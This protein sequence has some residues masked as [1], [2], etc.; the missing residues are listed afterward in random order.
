MKKKLFMLFLFIFL[1]F[2]IISKALVTNSFYKNINIYFFQDDNCKECKYAKEWLEEEI[3]N[4]NNIKIEY[5][6]ID[7]D[8]KLNTKV[9]N[10]L[11]IKKNKT[12]L[13]IIGSNYFIGFNNNIKND[14]KDAIKSYEDEDDFCDIV[15]RIRDNKN[16]KECIKQ[17]NGIYKKSN[18]TYIL[19]ASVIGIV[20]A[21]SIALIIKKK[22]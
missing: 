13:I 6:K 11:N 1:S 10:V 4:K 18:I 5:I 9:R 7:E 2:P 12:P 19:I 3:K 16:T 14:L 22:G 15:S 20:L 17:N 21:I 8:K